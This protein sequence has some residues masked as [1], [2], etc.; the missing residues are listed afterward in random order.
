MLGPVLLTWRR[1]GGIYILTCPLGRSAS[2]QCIT[3]F[4]PYSKA[5]SLHLHCRYTPHDHSRHQKD[6]D[7]VHWVYGS[8]LRGTQER[9]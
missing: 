1:A 9:M 5:V 3:L 4:T 8:Q 7:N 6:R 2:F